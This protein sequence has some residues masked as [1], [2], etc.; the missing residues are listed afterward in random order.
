[1]DSTSAN[2]GDWIEYSINVPSSGLYT[3]SYRVAGLSGGQISLSQGGV[4][5]VTTDVSGTGG[6]EMWTTVSS[7]P[8][9]LSQGEQTI[10]LQVAEGDWRINWWR[11]EEYV[12]SALNQII[13]GKETIF[14]N[15][16]SKTLYINA[17]VGVKIKIYNSS[18]LLIKKFTQ[19][20]DHMQLDLSGLPGGIYLLKVNEMVYKVSIIR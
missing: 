1:M 10:R 16:A 11:V 7:T 14:P 15:P 20:N 17:E 18:G 12:P 8:V 19:E 13:S 2:A 6:P 9:N 4:N 5:V 3:V